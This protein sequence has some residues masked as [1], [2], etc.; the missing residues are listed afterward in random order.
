MSALADELVALAVKLWGEPNRWQS[1]RSGEIGFGRKGS[2]SIK[3]TDGV[4]YDHELGKGGGYR[5]LY[6][7]VHGTYPPNGEDEISN[8]ATIARKAF[9]LQPIAWWDYHDQHGNIIARVV[10]LEP[11]TFRQCRPDGAGRWG[12]SV[13]GLQIPLYRLP[14]VLRAPADAN[15]YLNEGE[16]QA[17]ALRQRGLIATT[18]CM[19]AGRFR[20]HHATVLAGRNVVVLPDN[21]EAGRKHA[22]AVMD[23][24]CR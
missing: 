15:V 12:W 21:D 18:N 5:D 19:G 14:E 11:K 1:S 4:F 23:E 2:K 10:R 17:D 22:C 3:P 13:K 8:F 9:R 7:L 6:K 24:L 16:K 20:R